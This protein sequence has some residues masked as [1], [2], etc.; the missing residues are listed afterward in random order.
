MEQHVLEDSSHMSDE[1]IDTYNQ[2]QSGVH[3]CRQGK[4]DGR[5]PCRREGDGPVL[6]IPTPPTPDRNWRP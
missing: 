1:G 3:R 4:E 2:F 6:A 5:T